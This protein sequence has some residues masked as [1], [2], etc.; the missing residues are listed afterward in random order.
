MWKC[1]IE[2]FLSKNFIS[3]TPPTKQYIMKWIE[4]N[5]NSCDKEFFWMSSCIYYISQNLIVK[6]F[7]FYCMCLR[8]ILSDVKSNIMKLLVFYIQ[9]EIFSFSKK[10][11]NLRQTFFSVWRKIF[12]FDFEGMKSFW[13]VA[14]DLKDIAT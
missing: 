8:E 13:E 10:D 9:I 5:N 6:T 7:L 12:N 3:I 14:V 4:R 11:H 1:I 2:I